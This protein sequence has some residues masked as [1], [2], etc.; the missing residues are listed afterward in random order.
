MIGC[1][2][3]LAGSQRARLPDRSS[4][5]AAAVDSARVPPPNGSVV[6]SVRMLTEWILIP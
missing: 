6:A 2:P 3:S 5:V 4:A 1:V